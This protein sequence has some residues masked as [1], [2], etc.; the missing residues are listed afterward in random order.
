MAFAIFGGILAVAKAGPA[1]ATAMTNVF[2]GG[3]PD[4]AV[5]R[6]DE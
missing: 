5:A 6:P 1:L 2:C 3:R 4:R